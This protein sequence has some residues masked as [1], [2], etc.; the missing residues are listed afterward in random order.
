MDEFATVSP[1]TQILCYQCT[2][3]LP[4]QQGSQFVTCEFCGA[5]NFVDKSGAVLHY[6]VRATVDETAAAAALRR[7]MGGNATVKD[8]DKKAMLERPSFQM[9]PMWLVRMSQSG[10]EKVVLEPAAALAVFELT[11]LSIP[12]SDLEPYDHTMDGDAIAPTVPLATVRKWLADNQK[13]AAGQV[14]ES[15]LVHLPLYVFKYQFE[16]RAYTAV[17][18]AASSQVFASV[19]PSKREVPYVAIGSVG[20]ALYFCAALIPAI[21]FFTTDGTGL[22]W[23]ILG[24]IVIAIVL[25]VPI[26]GIA[27]YISSRV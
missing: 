26:F 5:T 17:V 13:I 27:A 25:A 16:G 15:S 12:A 18:D 10:Q 20:C 19:Y 8:L 4:V 3:V 21:S 1:E 23:G 7:W 11:E 24:Y 2:A 9:F 14:K 6:A 22:I